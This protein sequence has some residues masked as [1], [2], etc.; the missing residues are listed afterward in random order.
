MSEHFLGVV[1]ETRGGALTSKQ[2]FQI[3][4]RYMASQGYQAGV[5]E[6]TFTDQTNVCKTI[7]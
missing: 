6:E 4:L 1:G 5:A 2:K 3:F 7:Q